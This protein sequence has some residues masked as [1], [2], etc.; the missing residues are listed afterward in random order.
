MMT[1]AEQE[2]LREIQLEESVT[3]YRGVGPKGRHEGL[4]WTL[5]IDVAKFF[6]KRFNLK[7]AGKLYECTIPSANILA[8]IEGRDEEELIVRPNSIL[9]LKEMLI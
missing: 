4:S 3:A 8:Y 6:L 5:D 1:V 9:E 2:K 7:G